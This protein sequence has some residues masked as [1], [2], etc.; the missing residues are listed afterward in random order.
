[1]RRVVITGYGIF[2]SL[3]NGVDEV[4]QSLREG[5]SGIG[6]DNLRLELGYR[7]GLRGMLPEIDVKN[8]L[9]RKSRLRYAEHGVYAYIATREALKMAKIDDDFLQHNEVGLIMGNDSSAKAVIDG[10]D[11]I[12]EK[13]QTI[14]V[15]SGNVFQ[16]MNSTL[17]MNLAVSLGIKGISFTVS[18]ACA[19]SSHAI[20]LAAMYIREGLQDRI[21]CGGAQEVNQYS[22]GSFDGMSVFSTRMD[23]PAKA[24]RP[25]D[26]SRDG[27]VPSGGG[28][29]I[30][31]ESLES[32]IERKANII[33]EVIGYGFSSGGE[34]LTIPNIDGP[35]TAMKRA[36]DNAHIN[37]SEIGYINAHATSTR[38]GDSNEARAID[39]LQGDYRPFVS[40][41]KSMTGHELWMAGTSEVIYSLIMMQNNFIAPNIN[42]IEKDEA[43]SNLNIPTKAIDSKFD[44]FLSNSFGFGGTNSALVVKRF[45]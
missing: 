19:S 6:V 12:R 11:I 21:I 17:S 31:L 35:Y 34:H 45:E 42:L 7:S 16:T 41:T 23:E 15:G 13:H 40:S 38:I 27:L 36:I 39:K 4:R 18:A 26:T 30:I 44:T 22:V 8:I 14:L 10:V 2:S 37:M 9:D 1:M 25:F 3:G 5:R 28:A 32:A 20:G 33:A 43:A 24:S 29:A